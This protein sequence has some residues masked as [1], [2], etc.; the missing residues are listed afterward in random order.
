M[1]SQAVFICWLHWD[2]IVCCQH[3]RVV[4]LKY[5]NSVLLNTTLNVT[6]DLISGLINVHPNKIIMC[7]KQ[8]LL[9]YTVHCPFFFLFLKKCCSHSRKC[10]GAKEV[11][12]KGT[13]HILHICLS[14]IC[15]YLCTV[16]GNILYTALIL[17]HPN[18]VE[19]ELL[20]KISR[21]NL[22]EYL[23]LQCCH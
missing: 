18:F 6:Q 7:K 3:N 11:A 22:E 12:H 13:K 4:K 2:A 21:Y 15:D 8:S 20:L 14:R 19:E 23:G 10:S 1:S 16:C 17:N 5:L 9:A